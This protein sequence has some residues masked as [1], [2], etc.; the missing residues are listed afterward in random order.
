V[1]INVHVD[2]R[3]YFAGLDVDYCGN[4]FP[5]PSAVVLEEP[6]F[7]IDGTLLQMTSNNRLERQRHE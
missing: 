4:S 6:P 1:E 2:A 7:H 3:G 5:I